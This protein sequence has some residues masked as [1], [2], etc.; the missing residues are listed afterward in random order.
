[1]KK[2]L[3]LISLVL[4]L[5]LVLTACSGD[6]IVD[7]VKDTVDSVINKV[8]KPVKTDKMVD[9]NS[10]W[11]EFNGET[12]FIGTTTLEELMEEGLRFRDDDMKSIHDM[13]E[14]GQMSE[15]YRVVT[16]GQGVIQM[17][18]TNSSKKEKETLK[19]PISEIYI[20]I[21]PDIPQD[22]IKFPFPMDLTLDKL[23]EEAP[24]FSDRITKGDRVKVMYNF[25]DKPY[26]YTFDFEG[27]T[28]KFVTINNQ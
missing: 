12:Y 26:G 2:K 25:T 23:L 17:H 7:G 3:I 14:P 9:L 18:V 6:N 4:T 19:V 16:E 13:L 10:Q 24:E 20:S 5:V 21:N 15:S 11:F 1:M 27:G 28:L 22:T 8:N